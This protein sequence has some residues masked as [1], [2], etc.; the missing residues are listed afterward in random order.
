MYNELAAKE[1]EAPWNKDGFEVGKLDA[2]PVPKLAK[3]DSRVKDPGFV[4]LF[5]RLF[6]AWLIDSGLAN[7]G[8]VKGGLEV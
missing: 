1:D 8:V 4:E 5:S 6:G 3:P 7:F 2:V